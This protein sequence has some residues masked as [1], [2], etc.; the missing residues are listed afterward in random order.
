MP[1]IALVTL[2]VALSDVQQS[3]AAAR[4]E[5]PA[6]RQTAAAQTPGGSNPPS[7]P[8]TGPAVTGERM[9]CTSVPVTGSRFPIRRCRTAEQANLERIESQEALRRSQ[10]ARVPQP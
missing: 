9:I 3:S 10:G 1:L 4:G 7:T 6:G 2:V 5:T 8:G